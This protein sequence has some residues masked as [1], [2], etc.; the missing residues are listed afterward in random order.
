[1][2]LVVDQPPV[3]EV[4]NPVGAGQVQDVVRCC[5]MA[6]TW[7]EGHAK[8]CVSLLGA[9]ATHAAAQ[10]LAVVTQSPVVEVGDPVGAGQ[11]QVVVRCWV[12]PPSCP[13]G[14]AKVW[15]SV[16]GAGAAQAGAQVL[17]VCVQLP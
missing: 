1:M 5:V 11:V 6:P 15:L 10:V 17:L 14:H 4:G 7:P 3:V 8:V 13:L 16:D 12:M 9:G 2:L